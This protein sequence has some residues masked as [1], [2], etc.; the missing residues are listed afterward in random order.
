MNE[1][2]NM[3]HGIGRIHL[4]IIFALLVCT[5]VLLHSAQAIEPLWVHAITTVANPKVSI[6]SD[7]SYVA[8]A[9]DKITL[10]NQKGEKLWNEYPASNVMITGDGSNII[11]TNGEMV[12]L[13]TNGTKLWGDEEDMS[14]TSIS[15]TPQ[16]GFARAG[17]LVFTTFGA[18]GFYNV[19]DTVGH[20]ELIWRS[21]TGD[22]PLSCAVTDFDSYAVVGSRQKI[23]TYDRHGEE[24][25]NYS[26]Y[27]N[28]NFLF[29]SN[30]SHENWNIFA[31]DDNMIISLNKNGEPLWRYKT[32]GRI[33]SL[34]ITPTGSYVVAGGQDPLIYILD[35]TTNTVYSYNTDST[36]FSV[37]T[38][39]DGN[40]IA[41]GT[42]SKKILLLDKYGNRLW[43]YTTGGYVTSVALSSDGQYLAAASSDGTIFLFNTIPNIPTITST[44][45]AVTPVTFPTLQTNTNA[46]VPKT[47]PV[48]YQPT[49]YPIIVPL[50][51]IAIPVIFIIL[52]Y[53]YL[54][55]K[56]QRL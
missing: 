45:P 15:I 32:A 27:G 28:V 8:V 36:V 51:I 13:S 34:A 26:A 54:R 37:A 11:G 1:S 17:Y 20:R 42:L 49:T 55:S 6:S 38:D 48:W 43:Q 30:P 40:Y 44:L 9:S 47:K 39:N 24:V 29:I 22:L 53:F 3:R 46:T 33:N 12:F 14:F 35:Q 19:D 50:I 21:T 18:I 41:A 10:F 5:I 23:A 31:A 25:W 52:T 56:L 2:S 4:K 16:R 7:G